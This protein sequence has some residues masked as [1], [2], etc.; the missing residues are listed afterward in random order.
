MYFLGE[1]SLIQEDL[2]S[3]QILLASTHTI[4]RAGLR[5]LLHRERDLRVVGEAGEAEETLRL[6]GETDPDIVLL[7]CSL[8]GLS[9]MGPKGELKI[10]FDKA[11]TLLLLEGSA[12]I[13]AAEALRAGAG[14]IVLKDS[15]SDLLIQGIR[16]LAYGQCRFEHES[17]VDRASTL[18]RTAETIRQSTHS[19]AFGLT[20]R[21]LEIV[22]KV[23]SGFSNREI[24]AQL[25]ISDDTVKH[26][27]SNIFNKV[28]AFNRLELAL[29]AIHHGFSG[30]SGANGN[31][32]RNEG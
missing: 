19:N 18:S 22:R 13:D 28:G 7:D 32:V 20:A 9:S 17:A 11:P 10:L 26:H 12:G 6:V 31:Q 25:S 1:A 5:N 29:F 27:L 23:V 16:N 14:G 2:P 24:A 3:I 21:E 8:K 30:G 4:F 15:G